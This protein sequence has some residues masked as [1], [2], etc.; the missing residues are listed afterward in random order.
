M[1]DAHRDYFNQ[2]APIWDNLSTGET[3]EGLKK[4][5]DELAIRPGSFI[6]DVGTG[7]GVLLPFLVEAAGPEGKVV[8]LD[9]A[10][11]MLARARAKNPGNVEFV[12]ADISCTPFQEDTFDEIICNSCFPHVTDKPRALA[13]NG[14]HFKAWR[15][16][17]HLPF[18]EQGGSKRFAP[19]VR[20]GWSPTI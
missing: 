8:A 11:E 4:I 14:P 6:L 7:T 15:E 13:E 9:I 20:G 5:I 3:L 2:K 10:E 16:A 12:L 17:G 18:H 1:A 19:V